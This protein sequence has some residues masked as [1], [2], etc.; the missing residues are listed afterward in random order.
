MK[1][2]FSS[3][4]EHDI[5]QGGNSD[6]SLE[7]QQL[8]ENLSCSYSEDIE[9]NKFFSELELLKG[10]PLSYMVPDSAMLPSEALRVFYVDP[11]WV[12]C[13]ID[14]GMSIGRNSTLDMQHDNLVKVNLKKSSYTNSLNVRNMRFNVQLSD[15]E[16]HNTRT[17][18][19]LNSQLVSGWPGL[20]VKCFQ[21]QKQLTLLR[22]ERLTDTIML[23]IADGEM[24]NIEFTQPNQSLYFGFNEEYSKI[25][26]TLVSLKD[27]EVGQSLDKTI[28]VQFREGQ[29]ELGVIDI[30]NFITGI[31]AN[32]GEDKKGKYFSAVEFA[33]Q[34]VHKRCRV[35]IKLD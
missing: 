31:M 22:L 18:F 10:V 13:L 2:W 3:N 20:E 8:L 24:N 1:S 12:T 5:F 27:G 17:G 26:Q 9:I 19:L 32:L 6:N 33:C 23:C 21:D 14:G 30:G 35:N 7:M 34:M 16:P 11:N 4:I 29:E 25:K 28:D 15:N